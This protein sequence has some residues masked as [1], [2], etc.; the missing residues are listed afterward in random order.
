VPGVATDTEVI[1]T[2]STMTAA[3][4]RL[5]LLL[6][7]TCKPEGG[8]SLFEVAVLDLGAGA[9]P[10][11]FALD[12]VLWL[13]QVG[14]LHDDGKLNQFNILIEQICIDV[15]SLIF[16][17]LFTTFAIIYLRILSVRFNVRI[18]GTKF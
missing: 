8:F 11:P 15:K 13:E 3:T 2:L 9:V 1:P 6:V 7:N 16:H 10:T 18:V 5:S 14:R 12:G 17:L 4:L